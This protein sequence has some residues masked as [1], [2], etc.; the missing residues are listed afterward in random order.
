MEPEISDHEVN[1]DVIVVG[2]G[3][4]GCVV[5]GSLARRTK[6]NI[7]MLEAGDDDKDMLIPI[8]SG[9]AKMTHL[10]CQIL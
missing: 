5:A 1:F 8:P 4:A 10:S 3:A 6:L 9:Y 2:G 7:L